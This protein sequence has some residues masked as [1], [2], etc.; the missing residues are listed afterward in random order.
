M[1]SIAAGLQ[2]RNTHLGPGPVDIQPMLS[3]FWY[4]CTCSCFEVGWL[5]GTGWGDFLC[6]K[7][8]QLINKFTSVLLIVLQNLDVVFITVL[9]SLSLPLTF[10]CFALLWWCSCFRLALSFC[11]SYSLCLGFCL[12]FRLGFCLR[13]CS[14]FQ[15]FLW[16]GWSLDLLNLAIFWPWTWIP[17]FCKSQ[18]FLWI[19]P[20]KFSSHSIPFLLA[21]WGWL[22]L[23]KQLAFPPKFLCSCFLRFL[24][25]LPFFSDPTLPFWIFFF[26]LSFLFAL[27]LNWS[28]LVTKPS[29]LGAEATVGAE[30]SPLTASGFSS[31]A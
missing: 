23:S 15:R 10:P 1:Q 30:G 19:F 31:W 3:K 4:Q 9:V 11:L 7:R 14:S 26:R 28:S 6:C 21:W 16:F 8:C 2:W 25:V 29:P 22:A 27:N 5:D 13:L 24:R 18:V 12:G 17:R 20:F